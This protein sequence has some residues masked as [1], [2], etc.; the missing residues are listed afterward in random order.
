MEEPGRT[1]L[2]APMELGPS[3]G[4][5]GRDRRGTIRASDFLPSISAGRTR[6]G[7]IRP[8]DNALPQRTR[9]GTVIGP[10]K[11]LPGSAKGVDAPLTSRKRSGTV[12]KIVQPAV[13]EEHAPAEESAAVQK[14]AT[15][16][17]V[18]AVTRLA[19]P[20][21]MDVD[22]DME[23]VQDSGIGLGPSPMDSDDELLLKSDDPIP[24]GV[25]RL[26]RKASGD[27]GRIWSVQVRS[28]DSLS[29]W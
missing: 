29:Y 28:E 17:Q 19:S 16:D 27:A 25:E 1:S 2:G 4:R 24:G 11:G 14:P 15:A 9:S 5:Q 12:M 23:A 18:T 8:S 26:G 13:V 3:V 20:A 21:P 10:A 22:D 7:T 6:S